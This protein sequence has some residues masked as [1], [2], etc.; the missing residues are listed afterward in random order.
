MAVTA[1][2]RIFMSEVKNNLAIKLYYTDTDSIFIDSY[3]PADMVDN[4][5][6][7]KW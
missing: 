3:L 2:A 6:L 7:G 5:A 4:K 1:Y